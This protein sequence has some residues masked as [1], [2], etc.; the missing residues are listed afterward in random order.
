MADQKD[1]QNQK[2]LN[3]EMSQTKSNQ[4]DINKEMSITKSF[5]EQIIDL[6]SKR[7]G[8]NSDVLSD[9]QDIANTL[10]DQVKQQKFLNSEKK[11]ARDIS[12]QITKIAQDTYAVTKDELGLTQTNSKLK[13]QQQ[14]LEKNIILAKQQQAKFSKMSLEGD[15]ES[16]KLNAEIARSL[17]EQAKQAQKTS[18]QIDSIAKGSEGIS[19]A[20]GVKTFGGLSEIMEK[21]PGLSKFSGPFK[22]AAEAAREHGAAEIERNMAVNK[23]ISEYKQ[24]RAEGVGMSEAMKQAGVNAKQ[25]K[26]GE[27]PLKAPGT[28][29]AGFKSLGPAIAKAFGPIALATTALNMVIKAFKSADQSAGQLAKS[30]GISYEE[31]RKFNQEIADSGVTSG[32]LLTNTKDV[33]AAQI[34]LNKIFGTSLKFSNEFAAEFSEI[35]KR[36]GLSGHAMELFAE[37]AMLGGT[38]IQDQLE[39]VTAVTQELNAQNSISLSAKDIQEGI[40]QMSASQILNNKMNTKEMANQ[41]FQAKMLGISQSQLEGVQSKLLDFESSIAAEM[42]AELLTGKQLNLEGAR[43]AALAGD[44]AK[45]AAELRKEVGTAAEFG[46]MNVIQQEAMAKAFG[47]SRDDMSKMLIEQEK[48]ASLQKAFGGDV[49]TMSE[50]QAEYNRLSAAGEL[51][52]KKKKELAEAG[53][54]DQLESVSQQEKLTAITEKLT[55]LFIQLADPL[56]PV[57]S[58]IM[59]IGAAIIQFVAPAF[60]MLGKVIEGIMVVLQPIVDAF[61]LIGELIGSF[62]DPTQSFF[63]TLSEADPLVQGLA[64]AFGI[65]GTALVV[66]ILPSIAAAVISMGALAIEAGIAA[67]AAVTS[68]SAMTLGVGAI[69]IA[70][71]IATVVAAMSS[72]EPAGDMF[73]P[74][75]GRTQVSTKEGGLF[76]LSPNDD[77]MAAPGIS[78][79]MSSSNP[80]PPSTPPATSSPTSNT[81]QQG[82]TQ[83]NQQLVELNAKMSRLISIIEKGG[84]V[85]IDGAKVGKSL[86]LASSKIG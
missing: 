86:V 65:V 66:S 80:T 27:L 35:Q 43:A 41:V 76:E 29:K 54:L 16:R 14:T 26:V 42:E 12:N 23:G 37:K 3:N 36:T 5:E 17:G 60:K 30:Q 69:A 73:S 20:L 58:K 9:Q 31:A 28:L 52:E 75:D 19:K 82:T 85:I 47:L 4:K 68:A 63:D 55:D 79:M 22:E 33:V 67:V 21:V 34:E 18:T 57:I 2:D 50:A 72:A 10:Q 40:G 15:I 48:L 59:D 46:A 78:N 74:A 7:R 8:I 39:K 6:L 11:L 32:K 38:S 56:I 24:L 45:L 70:A 1:I 83:S 81:S 13:K 61:M 25:I 62:F 49:K 53:V 64:V 71:G 44:Q 51:T 77:F 84:D